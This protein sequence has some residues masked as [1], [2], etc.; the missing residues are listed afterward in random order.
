NFWLVPADRSRP[1]R[2]ITHFTSYASPYGGF[3]ELSSLWSGQGNELIVARARSLYS[4][5]PTSGQIQRLLTAPCPRP[6]GRC[7]LPEL[8]LYGISPARVAIVDV[9]DVGCTF[10]Q[11]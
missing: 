3:D 6:S 2:Q 11:I 4:L 1:A 5:D 9:E 7:P 10:C 8:Q